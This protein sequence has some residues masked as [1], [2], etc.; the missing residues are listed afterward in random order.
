[1]STPNPFSE[2]FRGLLGEIPDNYSL[3]QWQYLYRDVIASMG[4]RILDRFTP[5]AIGPNPFEEKRSPGRGKPAAG[6]AAP[7]TPVA[8]D[9]PGSH[10]PGINPSPSPGDPRHPHE[11]G[12]HGPGINPRFGPCPPTMGGSHGPGYSPSLIIASVALGIDEPP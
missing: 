6:K 11:S 10:G 2:R 3:E 12:S 4:L 7:G 1:M 5:D 9:P 8:S